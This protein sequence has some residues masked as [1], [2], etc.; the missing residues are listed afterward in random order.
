MAVLIH[1]I[2]KRLYHTTIGGSEHTCPRHFCL[3]RQSGQSE[4][5]QHRAAECPASVLIL[6]ILRQTRIFDCSHQPSLGTN[7]SLVAHPIPADLDLE[8]IDNGVA[9]LKSFRA[10]RTSHVFLCPSGRA[11]EYFRDER[12]P[13][14]RVFTVTLSRAKPGLRFHGTRGTGAV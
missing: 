1:P 3:T 4:R 6:I 12:M 5:K 10:S 2:L 14:E 7:P 9:G 11:D 8:L 13:K